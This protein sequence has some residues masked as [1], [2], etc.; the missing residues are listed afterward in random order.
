MDLIKERFT[1]DRI[2]ETDMVAYLAT[3]GFEPV[4]DGIKKDGTD[5]WYIS[6]LRNEGEASFHVNTVKNTWY[7]FPDS[8]G[9]NMV[10]FCLRY[11]SC[12]I[13]E[14]L[15]K[16]NANFSLHQLP[17]FQPELHEGL[18][19]NDSKLIVTGERP[20]YAYPLKNYLHERLIPLSVAEQFCKEVTYEI[21]GIAYYGIGFRNDAG[22]YEIRNKNYKQS[23]SPKDITTIKNGAQNVQ[24]FE[25]FFDFLTFRAMQLD[26]PENAF[27]FV[28]LN[29]AGMFDRARPVL[30]QYV[31]IGLWL[32]RDTTGIAYT[33]YALSL[34]NRYKDESKLYEGYKDLND[35]LNKKPMG[36]KQQLKPKNRLKPG[37]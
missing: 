23:S 18:L 29:G 30:E 21:N 35:W 33:E 13:R 27:D 9:G 16:F 17:V 10:D 1:L 26:K 22:G 32:D 34:S 12:S 19:G 24:V 11:H 31:S 7:D 8:V 36:N 14:L 5:Y 3:L 20:L 28:V 25:G 37:S 4:R 15:D 6:P 2:R